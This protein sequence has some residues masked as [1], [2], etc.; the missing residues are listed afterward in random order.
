M[1]CLTIPPWAWGHKA[2]GCPLLGGPAGAW[3]KS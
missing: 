1:A 2:W 3:A